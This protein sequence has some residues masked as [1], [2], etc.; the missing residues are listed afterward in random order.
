MKGK[1]Y[2]QIILGLNF[3]LFNWIQIHDC[4]EQS[5]QQK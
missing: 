4:T 2:V 1:I 5:K 3:W